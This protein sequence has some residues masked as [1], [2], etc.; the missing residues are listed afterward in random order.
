[1]EE[2][3]FKDGGVVFGW[4]FEGEKEGDGGWFRGER[5]ETGDEVGKVG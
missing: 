4:V 2:G 1:M 5:F 3:G